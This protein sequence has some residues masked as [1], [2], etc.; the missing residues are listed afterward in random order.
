MGPNKSGTKAPGS[1][2]V[3]WCDAVG[4][5][6]RDCRDFAEAIRANV[7]YLSDGRVYDCGT[8]RMLELNVGRGWMKRLMEE[9]AA[10]L[11]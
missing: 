9:A 7:V 4:H 3:P 1:E 5:A 2:S 6:R 10:C 8:R 11:L